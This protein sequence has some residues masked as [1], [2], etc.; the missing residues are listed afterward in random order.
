MST[1]NQQPALRIDPFFDGESGLPHQ[2]QLPRYSDELAGRQA[3]LAPTAPY[4]ESPNVRGT[5]TAGVSNVA[6]YRDVRE[7]ALG[8]GRPMAAVMRSGPTGLGGTVIPHAGMG[9]LPQGVRPHDPSQLEVNIDPH[10]E[11]Q[12]SRLHLS[13]VRANLAEAERMANEATPEPVNI[14]TLRLRGSAIM[15]GIAQLSNQQRQQLGQSPVEYQPQPESTPVTANGNIP[16]HHQAQWA[17][18]GATPMQGGG[19][20]Q[21]PQQP[22]RQS[23]PLQ[24]FNQT[25]QHIDPDTGREM[26]PIDLSASPSPPERTT[27]PDYEVT[28]EIEKFGSH[29]ANYHDVVIQPGFIVL[30]YN[31]NYPGRLYSPPAAEDAPA[32]AI[33][34]TGHDRVYLVHA[35]GVQYAYKGHEFCVL[36]IEREAA[37]QDAYGG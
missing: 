25:P 8:D 37:A 16:G 28:F 33:Q 15:H 12:R 11:G 35:T 31:T 7:M 2:V 4:Q 36:L 22:R 32:M 26:R 21:Q 6:G 34:I 17:G 18:Q 14:E 20:H 24:A 9:G 19:M 10:I 3:V 13:D 23:R 1:N 5:T 30:V 27:S 29:T